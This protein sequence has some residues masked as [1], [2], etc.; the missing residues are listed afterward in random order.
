MKKGQNPGPA[1]K[2]QNWQNPLFWGPQGGPNQLQK[3]VLG[4]VSA[5]CSN[6]SFCQ[7]TRSGGLPCGSVGRPGIPWLELVAR[8]RPK[9]QSIVAPT[10]QKTKKSVFSAAPASQGNLKLLLI[11][12][13][14][15]FSRKKYNYKLFMIILQ[16][17]CYI[18]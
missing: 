2:W 7:K 17:H 9:R 16:H 1:Q 3:S 13:K 4:R 12:Y 14:L 15:Y 10:S 8:C 6:L 18:K 11:I 5:K